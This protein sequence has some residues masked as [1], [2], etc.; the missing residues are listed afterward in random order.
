VQ[1]D[2][3]IREKFYCL[4]E[5][6]AY[7]AASAYGARA[8]LTHVLL[9]DLDHLWAITVQ[10]AAF[11]QACGLRRSDPSPMHCPTKKVHRTML[12]WSR[13][14]SFGSKRFHVG[15]KSEPNLAGNH[16]DIGGDPAPLSTGY[17]AANLKVAALYEKLR[18]P[19]AT[20]LMLRSGSNAISPG[21]QPAGTVTIQDLL[22]GDCFG[23]ESALR[24]V[25]SMGCSLLP[26]P[27]RL[28]T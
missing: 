3:S 27:R 14:Y 2:L 19:T 11:A 25:A 23:R 12:L 7:P 16:S 1:E 28:T 21:Q 9:T 10:K 20:P 17:E 13:E 5:A 15:D 8:G 4:L 18:F 22:V 6:R 24:L 26:K